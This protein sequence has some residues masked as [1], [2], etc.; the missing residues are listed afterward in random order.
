MA[1]VA[2]SCASAARRSPSIGLLHPEQYQL[3]RQLLESAGGSVEDSPAGRARPRGCRQNFEADEFTRRDLMRELSFPGRDP[4]GRNRAPEF[5]SEKTDPIR[6]QAGR[7]IEGIVTNGP[8]SAR[9][10]T[11]VA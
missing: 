10:W 5:I 7:V 4:R 6:L 9:S 11:S 2:P 8:A 1:S 3:A